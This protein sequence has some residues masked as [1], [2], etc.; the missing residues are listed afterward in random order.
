MHLVF[1]PILTLDYTA[2]CFRCFQARPGWPYRHPL[3]PLPQEV[4]SPPSCKGVCK[5]LALLWC[6]RWRLG[7]PAGFQLLLG[8]AE[9]SQEQATSLPLPLVCRP[10]DDMW[11]RSFSF[12]R[13]GEGRREGRNAACGA[14]SSCKALGRVKGPCY[15]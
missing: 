9:E 6:Q 15:G 14:L 3:Q 7:S 5:M 2:G 10:P 4:S 8:V 11:C 13:R 12:T 1:E